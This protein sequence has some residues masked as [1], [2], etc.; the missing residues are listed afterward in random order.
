MATRVAMSCACVSACL[1]C[2]SACLIACC[3]CD[4]MNANR[5]RSVCVS[6]GSMFS[7]SANCCFLLTGTGTT[8]VFLPFSKGSAF[9]NEPHAPLCPRTKGFLAPPTTEVA[10]SARVR[11]SVSR[12]MFIWHIDA[13]E[14]LAKRYGFWI[15]G[16][17]DGFSRRIIYLKC[18]MNKLAATVHGI[19]RDAV[20]EFGAPSCIRTDH[21]GENRDIGFMIQALHEFEHSEFR[22]L[23][24]PS[25]HNQRIEYLWRFL[26]LTTLAY[27]RPLFESMVR[28]SVAGQL[29]FLNVFHRYALGRTFQTRIQKSLDRFCNMW[30]KHKIRGPKCVKGRG[31]GVPIDLFD[32]SCKEQE[33]NAIDGVE[34]TNHGCQSDPLR[35]FNKSI[36]FLHGFLHG[37]LLLHFLFLVFP[38]GCR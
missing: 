28:G 32:D 15:H 35:R 26:G 22:W 38:K 36:G 16:C 30:N 24:G 8:A 13:N 3:A 27:F 18:S 29:R 33:T 17:I 20:V 11:Y 23:T 12:A 7:F 9:S 5:I 14:K 6:A 37:F 1:A 4:S 31:G 2:T 25:V 34:E 21:G 19:F 10:L